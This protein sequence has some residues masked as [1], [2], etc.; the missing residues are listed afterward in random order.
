[1]RSIESEDREGDSLSQTHACDY[2][3]LLNFRILL[4]SAA[5]M[6]RNIALL[7]FAVFLSTAS[8]AQQS[9][10]PFTPVQ[11]GNFKDQPVT[12]KIVGPTSR[13]L[14]L[15][16]S[17]HEVALLPPG[18]YRCFYRFPDVNGDTFTK[19]GPF[20]VKPWNGN[21]WSLQ[22]VTV[23]DSERSNDERYPDNMQAVLMSSAAEFQ[24]AKVNDAPPVAP[25]D[26]TRVQEL[27]AIVT[28]DEVQYA[29]T[30]AEITR[31]KRM[32]FGYLDRYIVSSLLPKFRAKGIKVNYAGLRAA[33][34]E[35]ITTP[36]LV[37]AC[38]EYEGGSYG[39]D[40]DAREAE[41]KG[42]TVSCQASLRHPRFEGSQI[43]NADIS[44][45]TD[46]FV[47][48]NARNPESVLHLNALQ[49][50][51]KAFRAVVVDLSD[52]APRPTGSSPP[53]SP[54]PRRSRHRP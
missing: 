27:T 51:G 31:Q 5:P 48:A 19:S 1:M 30:P 34:P 3:P 23:D 9:A 10:P 36:L 33:E 8:P 54:A 24:S 35:T 12:V 47:F 50:L 15:G 38:S 44:G 46:S 4:Y 11:F 37:V 2:Y 42:V 6:V 20:T 53:S 14:R 29:E 40:P 18:P 26:G 49:N 25:D 17:S 22:E 45:Y 32:V 21:P 7:L 41:A 13:L 16:A 43:W 39:R 28:L 52:W